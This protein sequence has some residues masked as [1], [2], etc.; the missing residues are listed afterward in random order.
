MIFFK[1]MASRRSREDTLT[2]LHV[3]GHEVTE[4]DWIRI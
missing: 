1:S 3:E 4:E 2:C